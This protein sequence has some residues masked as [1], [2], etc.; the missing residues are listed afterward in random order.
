MGRWAYSHPVTLLL[1]QC[2]AGGVKK[3][4]SS[5]V[6]A[7]PQAFDWCSFSHILSNP[8]RGVPGFEAT[9]NRFCRSVR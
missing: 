1:S 9:M 5:C 3:S 6:F 8:R 2:P 7:A 4:Q